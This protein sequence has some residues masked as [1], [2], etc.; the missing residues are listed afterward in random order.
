MSKRMTAAMAMVGI[1][2]GLALGLF[3]VGP[4]D[5]QYTNF[6]I[7]NPAPTAY[8]NENWYIT[9]MDGGIWYTSHDPGGLNGHVKT[10]NDANPFDSPGLV[11]DGCPSNCTGFAKT[12]SVNG[13]MGVCAATGNICVDKWVRVPGPGSFA[14]GPLV[15]NS[16]CPNSHNIFAL[17]QNNA[18]W[19]T[20]FDGQG[21]ATPTSMDSGCAP[22]NPFAIAG[23]DPGPGAPPTGTGFVKQVGPNSLQ[24]ACTGPNVCVGPWKQFP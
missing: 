1:G 12:S 20:L 24:V 19:Y 14:S 16:P 6:P 11:E 21:L 10:G 4:A 15:F 3:L 7:S 5:A 18:F 8:G 13:L 22:G 9:G 2:V 17:G 23:E